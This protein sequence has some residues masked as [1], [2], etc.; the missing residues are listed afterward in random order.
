LGISLAAGTATDTVGNSAAAAGPGATFAVDNT[1]P[2][3]PSTP[4]M[5]DAS[6]S[7]SSNTDNITNVTTPTFTGTAEAGST[8][9]ILVDGVAKGSST[10]TGGNYS[11]TTSTLTAGTHSITATATDAPGN[12]SGASGPLSVI[13]DTTAPTVAIGAPSASVTNSGPVTYTVTYAD[14]NFNSSTLSAGDIT[15]NKTGTANATVA[16]SGTG[17]TRTVTLSSI[18]GDGSLGISIAAGT[19]S[20]TAGNTTPAAGPSSTF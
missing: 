4:D 14:A 2:A 5:T 11:V 3:A 9:T 7:G 6:D 12:V 16:V 20:D 19:A 10:A 1:P 13:I 17:T 15:L 18:T 8:V